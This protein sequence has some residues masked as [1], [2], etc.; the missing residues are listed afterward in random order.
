[1]ER[2]VLHWVLFTTT[3]LIFGKALSL[4]DIDWFWA[5]FPFTFTIL[6]SMVLLLITKPKDGKE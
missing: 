6:G 4:I 2:A 3:I 5:F 1:M